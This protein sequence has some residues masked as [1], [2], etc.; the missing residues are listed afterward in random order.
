M[1]DRI[2]QSQFDNA[3]DD[4]RKKEVEVGEIDEFISSYTQGNSRDC[5]RHEVIN[6]AIKTDD[7]AFTIDYSSII[8]KV[9]ARD[10]KRATN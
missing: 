10:L 2:T 1:K 9:L 5:I 3:V 4:I 8:Q 7:R 6:L